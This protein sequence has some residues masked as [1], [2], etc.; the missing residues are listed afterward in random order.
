M[1]KRYSR[2]LWLWG[3]LA[4]ASF[5]L[6][7]AAPA[8]AQSQPGQSL[9]QLL[10][11]QLLAVLNWIDQLGVIAPL[12]F[13]GLYI[14]IT[15]ALVPAS[16]V[17]LGAGVVFGLFKGTA[18]VFVGAM[19]GA[20]A[21]FGIGRYL[22]RDWVARRLSTTPRFQ[23]IDQAIGQQGRR[24]V[25]LLR[26]SPVFPFTLLNYALGLTTVSLR[27]YAVGTLG[28]LPGTLLYVY[29][30]SLAGDLALLGSQ[31][32]TSPQAEAVQWGLRLAGLLAT[33]AITVYITQ[34]ARQALQQAAPEQ[35]SSSAN[36][37]AQ[38]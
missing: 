33:L 22:A 3:L 21:A 31:Q 30:G 34:I 24:I 4:A 36:D 13:I 12:A 20:I 7:P 32:A 28:I 10:Q 15:V 14:V 9:L 17:T 6:W 2:S 19:L 26:L 18:L 35:K 29:L 11:S 1:V 25:L 27:D 16:V 37:P 38:S 8:M 5:W 23:T